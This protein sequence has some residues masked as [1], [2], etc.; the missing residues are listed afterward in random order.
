MM[1][2]MGASRK[3]LR[4]LNDYCQ[5]AG[6]GE[7][8]LPDFIRMLR[9][10]VDC[11]HG[12]FFAADDTGRIC[13]GYH[14]VEQHAGEAAEFVRR[15][16]DGSDAF[17]AGGMP[18]VESLF[19]MPVPV[20]VLD[21]NDRQAQRSPLYQDVISRI[22]GRH[23]L[24]VAIRHQGRPQGLIALVRGRS[25]RGFQRAEMSRLLEAAEPLR[26]LLNG[27]RF[28]SEERMTVAEGVLLLSPEGEAL[29]SCGEGER[30]WRLLSRSRFLP[31]TDHQP[32]LRDI[33]S[34]L[35]HAPKTPARRTVDNGWGRFELEAQRLRSASGAADGVI[36]LRLR[37]QVLTRIVH[38]RRMESMGLSTAQKRVGL[39][40]L[41]GHTQAQIAEEFGVSVETAISHIRGL[42][43]RAGVSSRAEFA[44]ACRP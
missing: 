30:L 9:G 7:E 3:L 21:F 44:L 29:Q 39:A 42:Y 13:G 17:D 26:V 8:G 38:L 41:R 12:A 11:D 35:R 23:V 37:H 5:T 43:Q 2:T 19:R 16:R 24:R 32:L 4:N 10:W 6:S 20:Q 14:E 22:D 31:A 28:G 1:A 34:M 25:E 27:K 36:H 15:A 33:A 18:S 40:L